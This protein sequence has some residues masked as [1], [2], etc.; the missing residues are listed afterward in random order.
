M[1]EAAD[2][3]LSGDFGPARHAFR[4]VAL[5]GD[6]SPEAARAS[7][8]WGRCELALGRP[9]AA[10][11][12]FTRALAG[13]PAG[14][15]H[16]ADLR[17]YALAG[18]A[19]AALAS[20]R[21]SEAL[22][23]LQ[24]ITHEGLAGSLA[25]DAVLFRRAS[26]LDGLGRARAAARDYRRLVRTWPSSALAA[27]A[28]ARA[29]ALEP[30]GASKGSATGPSAYEVRAG[31][32]A[33]RNSA[34]EAADALR[35]RGFRPRIAAAPARRGRDFV[36]SVGSFD[37]REDAERAAREVERAGFPARVSP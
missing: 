12:A 36:V 17:A 15:S 35:G 11:A 26:A 33:D 10:R 37:R 34:E 16:V 21:P 13:A 2:L 22:D 5:A 8:S 14:T 31:V 27:G 28:L 30:P 7:H 29:D 25:A 4:R 24:R 19:D 23:H 18:L 20:G 6:G 3:F 32:Y 1:A 9:G